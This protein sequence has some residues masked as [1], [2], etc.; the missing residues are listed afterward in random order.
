MHVAR[1]LV[2]VQLPRGVGCLAKGSGP[3]CR[4]VVYP[5]ENPLHPLADC[6]LSMAPLVAVEV[7]TSSN[8]TF[9][10]FGTFMAFH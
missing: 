3:F 7:R 4:E 8:K 6:C 1:W 5:L 9:E 10:N 2:L